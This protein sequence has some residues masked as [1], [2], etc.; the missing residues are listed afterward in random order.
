MRRFHDPNAAL[1]KERLPIT[2]RV[3]M[4]VTLAV[5]LA[6]VGFGLFA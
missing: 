4:Y 2:Q 3:L 5:I 6:W 1:S